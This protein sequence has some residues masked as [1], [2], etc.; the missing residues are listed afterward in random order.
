MEGVAYLHQAIVTLNE[1]HVTFAHGAHDDLLGRLAAGQDAVEQQVRCWRTGARHD[2]HMG[3]GLPC[4][5][6]ELLAGSACHRA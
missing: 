1:K 2:L 3:S 6:T 5:H 4:C